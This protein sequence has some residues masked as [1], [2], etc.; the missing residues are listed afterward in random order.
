[1]KELHTCFKLN[2]VILIVSEINFAA[3]EMTRTK[4]KGK[5]SSVFI[6][7]QRNFDHL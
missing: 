1:M 5:I 3:L 6:P 4:I 7:V 2:S